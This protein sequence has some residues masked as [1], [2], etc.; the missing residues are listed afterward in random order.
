MEENVETSYSVRSPFK[1]ASVINSFFVFFSEFQSSSIVSLYIYFLEF[2]SKVNWD[3]INF[4][5][6]LVKTLWLVNKIK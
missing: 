5:T 3:P 1:V 6:M 4:V 2:S